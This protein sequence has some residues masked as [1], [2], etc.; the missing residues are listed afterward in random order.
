MNNYDW[1]AY[2][3]LCRASSCMCFVLASVEQRASQHQEAANKKA[4]VDLKAEANYG[5]DPW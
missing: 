5:S 4:D 1:E 3:A 2:E